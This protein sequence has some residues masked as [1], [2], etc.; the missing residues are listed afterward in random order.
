MI[1]V[2]VIPVLLLGR[3]G[4]VK[5]KRFADPQYL[6]DPINAV[7]IFNEKLADE[8]VILDIEATARGDVDFDRIEDI[9]SEGFMPI[10]YGG[11][12]RNTDQCAELFRRGVEKIVVNTALAETPQLVSDAAA[13][14]GSQSVVASIDV[15][16]NLVRQPRAHT[17]GGRKATRYTPVELA[18]A[19]V[20]LGAGEIMLTSMTREGTF[21]GYDTAMLAAVTEA[22]DVPVIA[23]GGAGRI[24][25][26]VDAV[27][28]GGCSAVAA[29]SLFVFAGKD[30]GVLITYPSEA[31]LA[32]QFWSRIDGT[33]V[34]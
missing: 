4:M 15:K 16:P 13:R 20:A 28:A 3:G 12:I 34:H 29:G 9:V 21:A 26:F 11:G 1:R 19:A 5:T 17:H 32:E 6:G 10:A 31:E 24:A 7:R 18:Q 8:L 14:F 2:R 23:N 25:H 30:A 22:V 33:V 27:V